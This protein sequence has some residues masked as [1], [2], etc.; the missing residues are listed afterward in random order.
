[1]CICMYAYMHVQIHHS[2]Y[3]IPNIIK[4]YKEKIK[5]FIPREKFKYKLKKKKI[6]KH[7]M[8]NSREMFDSLYI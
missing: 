4:P 7:L 5:F 1:M 8:A 3:N 2:I 6:S